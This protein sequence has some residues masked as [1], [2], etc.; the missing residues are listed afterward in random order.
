MSTGLM[1]FTLS[2]FIGIGLGLFFFGLLLWTTNRIPYSK[3]PVVLTMGSLTVRLAAALGV[4]YFVSQITG[5]QGIL[6]AVIGFLLV[7]LTFIKFV[8][9]QSKVEVYRQ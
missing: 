1:E 8:K 5:W 4:F 9:P 3:Y 2:L 6:S 7:K